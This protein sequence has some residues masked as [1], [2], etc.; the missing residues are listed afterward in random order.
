MND[1]LKLND[2][3]M[4]RFICDGVIVLDSDISASIH[5]TIY[6]KIQW[7]NTREFNMGNNVLPRVPELQKILDSPVIHGA[8]QSVLGDDYILHPHRFMHASEPVDAELR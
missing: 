5:Q 4:R 8:M 1:G 6:D 3:Q 7:N 2:E